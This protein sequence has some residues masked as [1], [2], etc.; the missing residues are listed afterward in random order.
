MKTLLHPKTL[1]QLEAA[2][3]Q[4]TGS[5][6][7]HGPRG[8]GKMTAARELAVMLNCLDPSQPSELCANCRQIE[9]GNFP[10]L[11]ILDRGEKASLTIEQ[12]RGLISELA[13]RPYLPHGV[14]IVIID[15]A[16]L[17]TLEAQNALLKLLEE[18]PPA[19]LI[20]LAAQRLET[21][22][23]TVRSRCQTVRFL[24]PDEAAITALVGT[25]TGLDIPAARDVAIASDGSPG[26]ALLL[27]GSPR[28]AEALASLTR[29]AAAI[30]TQSLFSRLLL[31]S[32]LVASGVDLERFSEALHHRLTA[33]LSASEISST[34]AATR[35]EALERFRR[36]LAAKVAPRVALERL[37]LELG[38]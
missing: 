30:Q 10:D 14:R 1:A 27:A 3:R 21:L 32:R 12:V 7:F 29:D 24:R 13:L 38:Q 35:L 37:M 18:P 8:V 23:L 33:A 19:T 25:R 4:A 9:A 5:L 15:D 2:A 6:I 36:H 11:I 26:L 17:L 16:H 28:E 31:A 20:I 34:V 22:L